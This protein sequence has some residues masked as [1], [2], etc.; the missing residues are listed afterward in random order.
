MGRIRGACA[1]HGVERLVLQAG[2][3]QD[4]D[5]AAA[6]ALPTSGTL[7]TV[8]VMGGETSAHGWA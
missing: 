6:A 7:A 5:V 3:R 8:P 1:Y 4:E 2:A